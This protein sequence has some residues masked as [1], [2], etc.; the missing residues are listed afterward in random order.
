[1]S[2]TEQF[3]TLVA[4]MRDAQR[5]RAD[6]PTR[7]NVKACED[8]EFKVDAWLQKHIAEKV[9]LELWTRGMQTDEQPGAYNV[10]RETKTGEESG[11]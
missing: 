10:T 7:A 2:T 4:K 1:M 5:M 3:I 8:I 9:Q 6:E 11:A